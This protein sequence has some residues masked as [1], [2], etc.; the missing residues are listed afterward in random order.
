L[1]LVGGGRD[2]ALFEARAADLGLRQ[3]VVEFLGTLPHAEA[4]RVVGEADVGLVPHH[5]GGS[6]N[7]TIPNKLFDYMAAGLP[8][9]SSDA[10]PAARVVRETGAGL[11]YASRDAVGLAECLR[12]LFDAPTRARMSAAG[13]RAVREKYNWERDSDV[14]VR[15][16]QSLIRPSR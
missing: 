8:V 4:L 5:A 3:P 11:V 15:T 12:T 9:V 16:L 2:R 6:W 1:R 14:L 7:T 10:A 13:R